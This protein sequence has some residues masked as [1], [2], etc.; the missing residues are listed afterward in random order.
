M[1]TAVIVG[2]DQFDPVARNNTASVTTTPQPVVTP[3]SAAVSTPPPVAVIPA[4]PRANLSLTKTINTSQAAVGT[5]VTFTFVIRNAGPGKATEVVVRDAVPQGL[6]WAGVVFISQG[7]FDPK[8]GIWH[9]GTL[10]AGGHAM[11]RVKARVLMLG[12]IVNHATAKALQADPVLGD[13]GSA[14]GFTGVAVSKRL[15][16]SIPPSPTPSAPTSAKPGS[17]T[18]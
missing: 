6:A 5:L 8:T 12:R 13:N 7:H 4:P 15:F 2:S 10:K 9:V 16:L 18:P 3:P 17:A 1:N 14:A 11:L